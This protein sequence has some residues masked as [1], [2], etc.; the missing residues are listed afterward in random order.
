[1]SMRPNRS[2]VALTTRSMSGVSLASP[3]TISASPPDSA[4]S[5]DTSSAWPTLGSVGRSQMTTLA[6]SRT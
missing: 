4:I 5:F 3:W 2:T 6:P 1:M